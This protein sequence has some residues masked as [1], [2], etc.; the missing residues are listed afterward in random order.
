MTPRQPVRPRRHQMVGQGARCAR[1]PV[2]A[3]ARV[4]AV[5]PLMTRGHGDVRPSKM[6]LSQKAAL[7]H[8]ADALD[9]VVA[10]VVAAALPVG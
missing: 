3:A 6:A 1:L 5:T 7:R 4:A 8:E 10:C 2:G 9:D